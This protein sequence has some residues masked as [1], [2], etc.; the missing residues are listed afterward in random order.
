MAKRPRHL[1]P[2][3]PVFGRAAC[4]GSGQQP[5][6]YVSPPGADPFRYYTFRRRQ[7]RGTTQRPF[8]PGF[9]DGWARPGLAHA[10]REDTVTARI[11]G[12][13]AWFTPAT[14]GVFCAGR[15]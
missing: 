15:V 4:L 1:P 3:G 11:R 5:M 8:A 13:E 2:C 9:L 10:C 7:Q 6:R 14:G 12:G